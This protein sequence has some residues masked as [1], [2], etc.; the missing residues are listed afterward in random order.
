MSTSVEILVGLEKQV[1]LFTGNADKKIQ[2]HED[3]NDIFEKGMRDVGKNAF[4]KYKE[5]SI[6]VSIDVYLGLT[7]LG[8]C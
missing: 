4:V 7:C 2:M 1:N 8:Y 3:L 6:P 5:L